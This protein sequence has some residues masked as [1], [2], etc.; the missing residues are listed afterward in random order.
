MKTILFFLLISFILF[1]A[2]KDN[3]KQENQPPPIPKA[4]EEKGSYSLVTKRGSNNVLEDLYDELVEKTP[5]LKT[6]ENQIDNLN[7]NRTESTEIFNTYK[8]KNAL[9]YNDAN[10]TVG[11]IKDSSIK[12]KIKELIANSKTKY[13][14]KIS[15]HTKLLQAIDTKFLTLADLHTF[16]KIKRTLPIMEKYQNDNLPS[17]KPIDSYGKHVD[18]VLKL[19][20]TLIKK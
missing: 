6:L 8:G 11:L 20:D 1:T 19:I 7:N 12:E 15:E 17:I 10:Q 18:D 16:L 9:Y 4:L 3:T 14:T 2:C 5:E 13:D